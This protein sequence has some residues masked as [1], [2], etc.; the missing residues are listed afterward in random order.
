MKQDIYELNLGDWSLKR[1][2]DYSGP[3]GEVFDKKECRYKFLGSYD[4]VRK[5]I[6]NSGNFCIVR[7]DGVPAFAL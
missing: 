1:L 6:F 7:I 2:E 3:M 4:D 5:K